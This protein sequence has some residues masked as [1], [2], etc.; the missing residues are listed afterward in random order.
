MDMVPERPFLM[1]EVLKVDDACLD[2]YDSKLFKT[3]H[4]ILDAI[5]LRVA[6]NNMA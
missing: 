1:H 4:V 2:I 6:S 5:L 3:V